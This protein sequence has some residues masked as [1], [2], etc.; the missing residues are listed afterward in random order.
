[1]SIN[2]TSKSLLLL[3]NRRR[4]DALQQ[5]LILLTVLLKR[6][7]GARLDEMLSESLD[8]LRKNT[9]KF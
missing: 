4:V 8:L 7:L 2:I 6:A 9:A 1:M 5:L 3:L